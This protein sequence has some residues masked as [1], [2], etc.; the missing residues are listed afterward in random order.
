VGFFGIRRP[1]G[2]LDVGLDR[3]VEFGSRLGLSW[4]FNDRICASCSATTLDI[5]T[6]CT[7]SAERLAVQQP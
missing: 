3:S 2:L 5:F 4:E 6:V 7:A 1:Y